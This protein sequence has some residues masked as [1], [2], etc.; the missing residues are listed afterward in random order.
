MHRGLCCRRFI[1]TTSSRSIRNSQREPC[2]ASRTRLPA[3]SKGWILSR[4]SKPRQGW[5][6]F[7]TTFQH[8]PDATGKPIQGIPMLDRPLP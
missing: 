6:S 7:S 8:S 3:L 4:N 1:T 2:G 5:V